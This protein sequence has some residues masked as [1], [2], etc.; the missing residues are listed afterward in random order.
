MTM[1]IVVILLNLIILGILSKIYWKNFSIPIK[2][3]ILIL[4]FVFSMVMGAFIATTDSYSL[5]VQSVIASIDGPIVYYAII[6]GIFRKKLLVEIDTV[7]SNIIGA[8]ISI[9]VPFIPLVGVA[10]SLTIGLA[11]RNFQEERYFLYGT[12][13]QYPVSG[14]WGGFK[15]FIGTTLW[16]ILGFILGAISSSDLVVGLVIG[17]I[18]A[19]ISTILQETK[20]L[21]MRKEGNNRQQGNSSHRANNNN[22]SDSY[23]KQDNTRKNKD[24]A[25]YCNILGINPGI[26][27][28]EL[29]KAYRK[30]IAE[31][32]P[33]KVIRLGKEL[34]EL[35][36]KKSKE[37]N[38]AYDVLTER[39]KQNGGYV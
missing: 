10:V 7:R 14:N 11:I 26:S 1:L 8:I 23:N 2:I 6:T 25:Y 36:E 37:I 31:Y 27:E 9:I 28:D 38:E 12:K 35:A 5:E 39:C 22:T 16:G 30:L 32:H 21:Q 3:L 15:K 24:I 13:Y 4:G 18:C 20:R 34:R 33:D 29:K 17:R 19:I